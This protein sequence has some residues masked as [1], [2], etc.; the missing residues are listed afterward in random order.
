MFLGDRRQAVTRAPDAF[1]LIFS[2]HRL[3]PAQ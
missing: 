2:S 1:L 3:P